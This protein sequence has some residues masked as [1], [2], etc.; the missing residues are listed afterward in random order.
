MKNTFIIFFITFFSNA[1]MAQNKKGQ[2][3]IAVPLYP[4]TLLSASYY[5]Q[6]EY[7]N[8]PKRSTTAVLGYQGNAFMHSYFSKMETF[9]GYRADIGQ[10]W[11]FRGDRR[12]FA[13]PFAGVNLSAEYSRYQLKSGFDVPADS[14]QSKG[15]SIGPE[16]NTGIKFV[17]FKKLTIAP[18]L[19]LRYYINTHKTKKI[20][21]NP[22]YWRYD[23]WDNGSLK[24]EDNK[25]SVDDFRRGLLPIPY[26]NVGF[27]LKL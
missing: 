1:V 10:R 9:K 27:I 8:S 15:V 2:F 16:V 11:Y 6:F 26:I 20:T 25:R 18:S 3:E 14:L 24:W 22:T 23:N 5:A 7:H 13:R 17:L 12:K 19:G 4:W 21:N